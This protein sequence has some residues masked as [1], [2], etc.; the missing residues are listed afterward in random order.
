M[1]YLLKNPSGII[2]EIDDK[3]AFKSCLRQPGFDILTPEE[4]AAY[5]IRRE[6]QLGKATGLFDIQYAAPKPHHDGYGQSHKHL[7]D[8]LLQVGIKLNHEYEGQ[9]VG[10]AY[11]YPE[12]INKLKTPTKILFSMFESTK[13]PPDWEVDLKKADLIIVPSAFCQK[14]F[15]DAGFDSIIVPLGY[16]STIF[17][18]EEKDPDREP[19]KF[20]HYD[21]FNQRKGWDIVFKAFNEEFRSENV[22][23]ILKTTKL[24]GFPFPILKS[25]YPNIDVIK[26]VY[27]HKDLAELL[28]SVDCFVLPSRGEGFGHPPLEALATGTPAIIPNAHGFAEF[29]TRKYFFEVE[30]KGE[31][32]ALYE[33]YKGVNTGVMVEP[34]VKSL[35]EQMRFVYEHRSY[36]FDMAKQGAAWASGNWGYNKTAEKLA[37]ILKDFRG[38]ATHPVHTDE[39]SL[40]EVVHSIIILTHNAARYT[41]KCLESIIENTPENYELIIIDNASTDDT[42][43]VVNDFFAANPNIPRTLIQNEENKG[44]AGGR[45]QGIAV[46]RGDIVTFLDNDTEVGQNWQEIIFNEFKNESV[47]VVGKGG[48]IVPFMKPIKFADPLIVDNRSVCDVVPGYCLSFRR[49]LVYK[50]GPQYE[51]L[52]NPLFWHEDLDFCIRVQL[53]GYQVIGNENIPVKHYGHKSIGEDVSNDQSVKLTKGYYE[54]AAAILER[55][56]SENIVHIYRN[57]N[58]FDAAASYDRVA[59]GISKGLRDQGMV[60]IFKPSMTTGPSSFNLCKMFDIVHNGKRYVNIHQENDRP[61]KDWADGMKY[62]DYAFTGSTHAF[63][64]CQ[65]EEYAGKLLNVSL[66]GV[67]E[68]IYNFDVKPVD[69]FPGKFKF[70]MVGATQPRKSSLNLIKWYSEV[71]TDKDDVVLIIKDIAYGFRDETKAYIER[72]R[73][74]KKNCPQIEYIFEDWDSEYLASV[75]KG[76]AE[77]GV[78]IHPHRAE[79]FGLPHIEAIACGLR[80]GTTN[81]GGP[82]FNL[83]GIPTVTFFKY[84]MKPSTFHN[85]P[86]EPYYSKGENPEWAEPD[87][88]EVKKFMIDIQKETYD[89][90][91][92]KKASKMILDRFSY[93]NV[94][95]KVKETLCTTK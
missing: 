76:T 85:H 75:Y 61:P 89:K 1:T 56:V 47:G 53:G 86:G 44:V 72:V 52:P 27:S 8:A 64:A 55:M 81:Y 19:F 23:L 80:V 17:K 10:L 66:N 49:E 11:G 62:V 73:K 18:Y 32:P 39:V 58:G 69:L 94:A 22:R 26:E 95:K 41:K 35:R 51:G 46:A 60:V 5:K 45:N 84:E 50:V 16:D 40:K 77:S 54:N 63:E 59:R 29:F 12:M 31:C 90:K 9:E 88:M 42:L 3:E 33:R 37:P 68:E 43:R 71:F 67:E 34:D 57:F 30:V 79:C 83:K 78:Y 21:A 92:A 38:S 20:L 48:Q 93:P 2:V 14:A 91:I 87:E 6:T 7:E 24:A 82:K 28:H 15:K 4:E 36:A 13:L 74:E 25:Q 70:L 65:N